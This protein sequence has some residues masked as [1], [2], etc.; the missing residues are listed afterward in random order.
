M[1]ISVKNARSIRSVTLTDCMLSLEEFIAV[2]KYGAKLEFGPEMKEAVQAS[3]GAAS[4]DLC[5]IPGW[6]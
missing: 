6:A 1:N 4:R 2:D 3:R 5:T